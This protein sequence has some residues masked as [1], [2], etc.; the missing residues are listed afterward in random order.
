MIDS[1]LTSIKSMV[2]NGQDP[3]TIVRA[4]TTLMAAGCHLWKD[5]V[6]MQWILRQV[7]GK[8]IIRANSYNQL[9]QSLSANALFYT[10]LQVRL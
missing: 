2:L 10:V 1:N 4:K 3:V 9:V 7:L 6:Q 8:V 5:H